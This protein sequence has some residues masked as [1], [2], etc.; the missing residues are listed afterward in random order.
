M[1]NRSSKIVAIVA[2][3]VGVVGLSLGFAAF[4]N[5]LTISSSATVT[6]SADTFKVVFDKTVPVNCTGTAT[7]TS[8]GTVADTTISGVEVAF[9][10]PGQ[11]LTC[12]ATIK[13]DGEYEAFLNSITSGK[14]TCSSQDATITT[15]L[16]NA[17]CDSI[18][19]TATVNGASATATTK[20]DMAE[21]AITGNSMDA[22]TGTQQVSLT[23]AYNGPARADG[24]FAVAVPP[25]TLT[26]SSVD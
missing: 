2:L 1:E 24:A 11:S 8:T 4:S 19:V 6:P 25:V 15:D 9:T 17:A 21:T 5:T 12:T 3:C 22:K 13:N 10:A 16:M 14:V 23:I 26:Y 20:T 7:A 18:E